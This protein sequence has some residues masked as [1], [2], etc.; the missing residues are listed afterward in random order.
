MGPVQCSVRD[1]VLRTGN[2]RF[3]RSTYQALYGL[4]LSALR[5]Y[6]SRDPSIAALILRG[7]S[8][9][10]Y[11]PGLSDIDLTV[12]MTEQSVERR[13]HFLDRFWR[14]YFN[15]R[16]LIPMLVEV[17]LLTLDEFED[18]TALAAGPTQ[19]AKMYEL[20][21]RR[22]RSSATRLAAAI[23]AA[24]R[25]N[26]ATMHYRNTLVRYNCYALP[27]FLSPDGAGKPLSEKLLDHNLAALQGLCG[28]KGKRGGIG[29]TLRQMAEFC[30]S[31]VPASGA[32]V[33]IDRASAN[34][35]SSLKQ[36]ILRIANQK[37]RAGKKDVAVVV[38]HPYRSERWLSLALLLE[39]ETPE[40]EIQHAA[41][42][43]RG[44]YRELPPNLRDCLVNDP[45]HCGFGLS[46]GHPLLMSQS[47][48]RCWLD[49]FPLE[50]AAVVADGRTDIAEPPRQT[51]MADF[52][53]IQYGVWL[54]NRNDWVKE[55]TEIQ[56]S[57]FDNMIQRAEAIREALE[58]GR[59]AAGTGIGTRMERFSR[60]VFYELSTSALL[61]LREAI[62]AK[63]DGKGQ[64]VT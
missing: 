42:A 33:F 25:V 24:N 9:G 43:L 27:L 4:A 38:W 40:L 47:M 16:R 48:W 63:Q 20:V 12:I 44:L 46:R 8:R 62:S 57:L 10:K 6:L 64:V 29:A 59:F 1:L 3:L 52:A 50:A 60:P 15:L 34:R 49:L 18:S 56:H 35:A 7:K 54:I 39:D 61:R 23:E 51:S 36:E 11:E 19:S 21:F 5:A 41:E 45:L 26:A 22:S 28:E 17:D 13:L 55:P 30:R 53:A 14:K 2:W 32:E 37:L 58:T 31:Y